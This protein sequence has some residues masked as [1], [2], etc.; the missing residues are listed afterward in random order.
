MTALA[1]ALAGLVALVVTQGGGA[2][3]GPARLRPP[4]HPSRHRRPSGAWVPPA[5]VV[6]FLVG[7][8]A[9]AVLLAALVAAVPRVLTARDRSHRLAGERGRALE[10]LS[11][12]A[13]ELRAGRPPAPALAAAAEVAV[14]GSRAVLAAAAAAARTGG[15]VPAALL[16]PGSGVPRTWRD[17]ATCWAVS[18][19]LGHGLAAGVDRLE[20]GLRAAEEQRREVDAELAG[21]RA[22]AALLAALPVA[23]IGLAAS[24][25][26]DP[27]QVLLH[28]PV[29]LTCLVL[30]LTADLVGWVWTRALVSRALTG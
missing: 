8:P 18:A 28:T 19:D 17:L 25:G 1:A 11:L 12:L 27:L 4:A 3:L 2:A 15:D 16:Q 7:G 20:G 23:G 29:G 21:P 26:A 10:A 14:D 6:G 24:L 9:L 30:G 5:A 13:A 22:T